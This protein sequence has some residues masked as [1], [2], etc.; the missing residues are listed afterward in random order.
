[1]SS[2]GGA[3]RPTVGVIGLGLIGGSIALALRELGYD[4]WGDDVDP[5]IV[6]SA[7]DRGVIT[8]CGAERDSVLTIVATPADHIVD[9]VQRALTETDGVVIDTGSVKAQIASTVQD[10]RFVP[11]HP[12]AGSEQSGLS[13]AR[14]ELFRGASWVI[15]PAASTSD[16]SFAVAHELVSSLGAD[17]VTL[18]PAAHDRMV[19]MVSHVPH[20]VAATLM[21]IAGERSDEHLAM[22]RLA[23]GGFRDM[24]RIA[25]GSPAIWPSICIQNDAAI[26]DALDQVID[27]LG[28]VRGAIERHADT[29]I[30]ARLQ[31]ARDARANLPTASALPDHLSEVRV[32]VKDQQGELAAVT[33]LAAELDVNIYDLEIAHSAEGPTGVLVLLVGR[34]HADILRGGLLARGYRPSTRELS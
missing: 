14:A 7:R 19:A 23:A 22:L 15:T 16:E 4:V 5:D 31:S 33:G 26:L 9:A 25:S 10:P 18:S 21:N 6:A 3:G 30:H 34:D 28:K 29:E 27:E 17:P 13:G 2:A 11:T 24:T 1:M 8:R 32:R 20:L 12:M